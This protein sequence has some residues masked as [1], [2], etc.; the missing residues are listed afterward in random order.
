MSYM[1]SQL[2]PYFVRELQRRK[3]TSLGFSQEMYSAAILKNGA[4]VTK[5][6]IS[7]RDKKLKN[8]KSNREKRTIMQVSSFTMESMMS[9]LPCTCQLLSQFLL[10]E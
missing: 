6:A 3:K 7:M 9:K 2:A 1:T 10:S 5:T 4:M 8:K